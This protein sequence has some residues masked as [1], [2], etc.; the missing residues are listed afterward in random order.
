MGDL[1]L[2]SAPCLLKGLG[3]QRHC[4]SDQEQ[5]G[6]PPPSTKTLFQQETYAWKRFANKLAMSPLWS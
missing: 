2:P 3:F 4:I 6:H 5:I 1:K